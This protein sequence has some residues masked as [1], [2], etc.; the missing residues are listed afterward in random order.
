MSAR[1][2]NSLLVALVAGLSFAA[3][4]AASARWAWFSTGAVVTVRN[5]SG[6]PLRS[7]ELQF[8]GAAVRGVLRLP[9]LRD[10]GEAVARLPVRGEGS[11]TVRAVLL[12][13]TAPGAA[14]GYVEGG[15]RVTEVVGPS[16]VVPAPSR[17][18]P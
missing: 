17:V 7:L 8:D 15:Y 14:Q 18:Y 1:H 10:G 12:D 5:R 16:R 13:G 4:A 9:A 3:G 11:Y 2:A 6:Q